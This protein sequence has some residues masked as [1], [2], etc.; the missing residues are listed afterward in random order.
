MA[1]KYKSSFLTIRID[2]WHLSRHIRRIMKISAQHSDQAILQELG[3]RLMRARLD[4]NLTQ[5]ALAEQSGVSKRTIERLESGEAAT[6]LS[7]FLRVCRTLGMLERFEMLVPEPAPSPMAQLKQQG[8]RRQRATRSK[9]E[10]PA[11]WTWGEPG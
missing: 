7:G 9:A 3:E 10:Q 1:N 6:Q 2:F 8:H 4:L 5:A 11:K